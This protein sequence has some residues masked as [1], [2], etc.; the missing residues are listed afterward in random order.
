MF[1]VA[2]YIQYTFYLY[3]L[4]HNVL[5]SSR[6]ST[7]YIVNMYYI[8]Q[9]TVYCLLWSNEYIIAK[10]STDIRNRKMQNRQNCDAMVQWIEHRI[11]NPGA[12]CPRW[13]QSSP[14]KKQHSQSSFLAS[15]S[16]GP[17]PL[18]PRPHKDRIFRTC[19]SWINPPECPP[20]DQDFEGGVG[21]GHLFNFCRV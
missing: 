18:E 11:P 20:M 12:L 3:T 19:F 21:L 8:I 9:S 14:R 17:P 13:Y 16:T 2:N 4:C 7:Y 10:C 6:S 15:F 1:C 5:K